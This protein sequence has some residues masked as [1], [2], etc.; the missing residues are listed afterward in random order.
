MDLL[1]MLLDHDQWATAQLL[2]VSGGLTEAQLDQEFDIG[3][4]SLRATFGHMIFNLPFWTSFLAGQ[5]DD[6]GY[7]ADVQPDDRSLTAMR[8]PLRALLRGLC[9]RCAAVARRAAS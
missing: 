6:G 3:H 2:K 8:P 5:P 1:D 4:R 7:S 9:K